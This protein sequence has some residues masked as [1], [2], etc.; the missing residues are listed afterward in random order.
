MIVKHLVIPTEAR[1]QSNGS[2]E[3]RG[4]VAILV[5]SPKIALLRMLESMHIQCFLT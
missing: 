5:P 2:V 4:F 3:R 1:S